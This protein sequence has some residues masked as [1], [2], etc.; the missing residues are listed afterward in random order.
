MAVMRMGFR[1]K[2]IVTAILLVSGIALTASA[3][4]TTKTP[5]A[6]LIQYIR[7]TKRQGFADAKIRSQAVAV[8]WPAA[9]VDEA[10]AYLR[11]TET[12][13]PT[14]TPVAQA[15]G[16]SAAGP[17]VPAASPTPK[18][19]PTVTPESTTP[20]QTPASQDSSLMRATP[21]D[22]VI[23]SGDTLQITV[24]N[25][26]EVSV[27]VAVVRPDGKITV[28]L[29][30]ELEVLGLTPVQAEKKITEGLTKYYEDPNVAVVVATINSKKI[31]VSGA[32]RKEGPLPY[33]YGMTVMQA[34][35]EAGGL[36]DYAKR[37]KIYIL[38]QDSGQTY[39]L[40]FNYDNVVKGQNM[41]QNIVLL[42]GDTIVIPH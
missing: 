36:N 10:F 5:P 39:R 24:W 20:K 7:E 26:P 16:P 8:G 6:E 17:V 41:E 37:K 27:P 32:A 22:Y 21:D 35:S 25:H 12:P 4:Q 19:L 28:P 34:L 11:S 14:A 40:D 15:A 13:T 30:K 1:Y 18:Q 31:Y 2:S 33:T 29:V 9:T 3:A 38:H 42:P 23:G